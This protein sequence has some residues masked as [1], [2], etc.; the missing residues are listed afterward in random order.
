V[1]IEVL[2]TFFMSSKRSLDVKLSAR[3]RRVNDLERYFGAR[4]G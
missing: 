4:I 2:L 1:R 3:K